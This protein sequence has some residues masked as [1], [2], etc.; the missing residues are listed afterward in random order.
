VK[1]AL[2]WENAARLLGSLRF[3]TEHEARSTKQG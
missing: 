3:G 1:R 2:L